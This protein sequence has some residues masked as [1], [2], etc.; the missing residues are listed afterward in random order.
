M[1][2]GSLVRAEHWLTVAREQGAA[3]ADESLA[4]VRQLL[5]AEARGSRAPVEPEFVPTLSVAVR[6]SVRRPRVRIVVLVLGV[7]SLA[8]AF[9]FAGHEV[10]PLVAV[11][12]VLLA[13]TW[14]IQAAIP[15]WRVRPRPRDTVYEQVERR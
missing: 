14:L 3:G 7:L 5:E 2:N 10:R 1:E 15:L 13:V 8:S 4:E 6:H 12:T 9:V 11:L